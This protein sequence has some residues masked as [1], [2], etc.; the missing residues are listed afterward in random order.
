MAAVGAFVGLLVWGL[1]T[2]AP[3]TGIDDRLGRSESAP[4]P[5]FDLPVLERG[6][7]G[8]PLERRLG[9]E[10]ADGRVA[11]A[12]LRGT[13][14]V[15]NFWASWCDPC[16]KEAP[17]L[18]RTWRAQ[19][20]RGVAFVGLNMQDLTADARGFLREFGVSYLNVRDR[21]NAVALKWGVTGLPETFF[22]S[23]EGEVVAHVVGIVSAAQLRRGV[24][25]ARAGRPLGALSGGERRP[26]RQER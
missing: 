9:P 23:G 21:S 24:D 12:E 26:T 5:G 25:A 8:P 16:R 2:K 3:E 17:L 19:R 20:G 1:A 22:V 14:V 13:P 18:E 4:A 10:L 15:L 6:S 11:L 7:L